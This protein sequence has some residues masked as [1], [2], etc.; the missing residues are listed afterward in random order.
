MTRRTR[1]LGPLCLLAALALAPA[2]PARAQDAP[3][4]M[5]TPQ[6]G[7]GNGQPWYGYAV[8]GLFACIAIFAV[9]KSARRTT[10][11]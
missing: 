1:W 8:F 7:G 5:D 3:P 2:V 9:S 10:S 11:S 6:E 4:P